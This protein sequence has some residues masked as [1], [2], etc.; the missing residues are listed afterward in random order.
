MSSE[1]T[2]PGDQGH[3]QTVAD[4]ASLGGKASAARLTPE[5]RSER[6][7]LAAEARWEATL[8]QATHTG[9]INLLGREIPCAVLDDE[10]RV[11][12]QEGFLLAIGRSAKQKGGQSLS[13]PD[14][15]PPFLASDNLKPFV[16]EELKQAT[17]PILFRAPPTGEGRGQT[18]KRA[19]GYDANLLQMVCEVYIRAKSEG[20][21]TRQQEHI[22]RACTML[23]CG[24]ARVGITSLVD[25]ATGYERYRARRALEEIL[26]RFI[27]KKLVEWAK[28]FPD[29]FYEEMFR[30][31]GWQY[32][33]FS[34]KR[35]IMAGKLTNDIV[36]E[37]L[38]SGVLDELK[39]ITP[40]DDKGRPKHKYFQRLTEDVGHPRLREHLAA[41]IALMRAADDRDWHSFYKM[42]NRAL[43]RQ[44]K[45]PLFDNLPDTESE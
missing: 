33:T 1:R 39:R 37:R 21:L 32:R 34:S 17:V 36:Y 15:L 22:V 20:K 26:E 10:R 40:K 8:P 19:Y 6:A 7:R 25:A 12:T 3:P 9:V 38:A 31:K 16:T 43:P 30:L 27:A 44:V 41:V 18:G 13:S 23:M 29:D 28:M 11:L 2:G 35:P 45:M 24:F 14:G 4:I 42:L 5:E